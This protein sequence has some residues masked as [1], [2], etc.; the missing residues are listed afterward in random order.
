MGGN[1]TSGDGLCA[2]HTCTTRGST[3][4]LV[5]LRAMWFINCEWRAQL[6]C[7]AALKSHHGDKAPHHPDFGA[8]LTRLA[9]IHDLRD[10][11]TCLK[12]NV[13]L[14][15]YDVVAVLSEVAN[16]NGSQIGACNPDAYRTYAAALLQRWRAQRS[17]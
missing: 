16:R 15:T 8:A 3:D 11:L 6:E 4:P 7:I 17:L 9:V 14:G 10:K 5:Y 12:Q 1:Y 13:R 2:L